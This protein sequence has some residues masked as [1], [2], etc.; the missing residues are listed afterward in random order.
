MSVKP[1]ACSRPP[2]TYCGA[3]QI[4][5]FLASRMVVVSG[6]ASWATE[7]EGPMS[8]AA[9]ADDNVARKRRRSCLVYIMGSL[10]FEFSLFLSLQIDGDRHA[11]RRFPV[12]RT[13]DCGSAT[14]RSPRRR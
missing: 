4:L 8:P 9:T 6:G 3:M 13:G 14:R 12:G 7:F 2:T 11:N 1:S 10:R 5:R